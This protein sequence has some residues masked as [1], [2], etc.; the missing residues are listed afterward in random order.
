MGKEKRA[1]AEWTM[2]RDTTRVPTPRKTLASWSCVLLRKSG[3]QTG[4]GAWSD[5]PPGLVDLVDD[6]AWS[7]P[8][9]DPVSTRDP[10]A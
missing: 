5:L 7:A 9:L 3:G 8:Y 2:R 6:D 1:S 4:A 10:W